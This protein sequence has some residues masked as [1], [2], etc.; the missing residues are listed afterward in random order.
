MDKSFKINVYF[1]ENGEEIERL[2]ERLLINILD[3][4][5]KKILSLGH[6]DLLKNQ[7]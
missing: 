7:L 1:D 4:K 2:I 5:T 6:L 3:K